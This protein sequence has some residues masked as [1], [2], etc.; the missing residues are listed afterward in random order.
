MHID[1]TEFKARCLNLIDE[2]V[3]TRQPVVVT[4]HGKPI[5]RIVPIEDEV[6]STNLFGH[7]EGT[8]KIVGD[9]I[10]TSPELELAE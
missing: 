7:M 3:A 10:D 6:S 9:I 2:V 4:K 1:A 8:G 5:A